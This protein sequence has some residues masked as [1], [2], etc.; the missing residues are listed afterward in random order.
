[1]G[2]VSL[3]D[4]SVTG[5]EYR[6]VEAIGAEEFDTSIL[7][8]DLTA[9]V[10]AVSVM[11]PDAEEATAIANLV[12][13]G[14][15]AIDPAGSFSWN[16]SALTSIFA[17][18]ADGEVAHIAF[19]VTIS[20]GTSDVTED[21]IIS[22]TGENDAP[23]TEDIIFS[24]GEGTSVTGILPAKDIDGDSLEYTVDEDVTNGILSL[25]MDGSFTYI[26]SADFI[27]RETFTYIATDPN[28]ATVK[29]TAFVVI[30]DAYVDLRD[31]DWPSDGDLDN[32]A[33]IEATNGNLL[34]DFSLWQ[35]DPTAFSFVDAGGGDFE[36][37]LS[38]A[39]SATHNVGVL[40]LAL[41]E[42]YIVSL[43]SGTDNA[44]LSVEFL[45]DGVVVNLKVG[46]TDDAPVF[47]TSVPIAYDPADGSFGGAVLDLSATDRSAFT[48]GSSVVSV[49]ITNNETDAVRLDNFAI[50]GAEYASVEEIGSQ[51]F[52]ASGLMGDVT[53][54]IASVE[55][56][57][58]GDKA[59]DIQAGVNLGV[60]AVDAAS[61]DFS[62][63]FKA[64]TSLFDSVPDGETIFI[65]FTVDLAGADGGT[66]S[67]TVSIAITGRNDP[68]VAEALSV[69]LDEDSSFSGTLPFSDVD[70]ETLELEI[71]DD[72]VNGTLI[73]NSDGSFTYTPDTDFNGTESFEYRV[74][75]GNGASAKNT[76]TLNVNAVNDSPVNQGIQIGTELQQ[77]D[78]MM[79]PIAV[80][81]PVDVQVQKLVTLDLGQAFVTDVDVEQNFSA[82]ALQD[83]IQKFSAEV[84]ALSAEIM[85]RET[86][87]E[88]D[89]PG[90]DE[91]ALMALKDTDP[92]LMMLRAE[93]NEAQ[94]KVDDAVAALPGAQAQ[95]ATPFTLLFTLDYDADLSGELIFL[96]TSQLFG[97]L[98]DPADDIAAGDISSAETAALA[99]FGLI[100]EGN[101]LKGSLENIN[102]F[103]KDG[104]VTLRDTSTDLTGGSGTLNVSISDG[105]NTGSGG[106]LSTDLGTIMINVIPGLTATDLTFEGTEDALVAGNVQGFDPDGDPITF[107]LVDTIPDDGIDIVT[108]QKNGADIFT[109]RLDNGVVTLTSNGFFVYTPD[110]NFAG[111]ETFTYQVSA[112][113]DID[114]AV[115][116]INL[117]DA[118]ENGPTVFTENVKVDEDKVLEN[119][120]SAFGSGALIYTL[121]P[122]GGPQNGELVLNSDGTYIY[123]PDPDFFGGDSFAFIVSDGTNS[124]T[125]TAVITVEGVQDAPD[126]QDSSVVLEEDTVLNGQLTAVDPDMEV[127]T[128]ALAEGGAPTH[129]SLMLNADGSFT[130]TPNTDFFGVDSFTYTVTD[131]I[132]TDTATFTIN[133][134]DTLEVYDDS[135][136]VDEDDQAD[137]VVA[138]Q[139]L[140]P[141]TLIFTLTTEPMLGTV[142][143]NADG[144]YSYTPDADENG[145]DSFVITVTDT[146]GTVIGSGLISVDIIPVNDA[147]VGVDDTA[148]TEEDTS[149][150]LILAGN[151]TDIDGDVLKVSEAGPAANGTVVVT[152][153]GNVLYTPDEDFYGTD[154]FT[155]T[156]DDGNGGT[157]TATATITIIARGEI[158]VVGTN[159]DDV[160]L[161]QGS[162][163]GGTGADRAFDGGDGYD[164]VRNT[165]EDKNVNLS[166]AS[167]EDIEEIDGN[168]GAI[169]VSNDQYLDLSTVNILTDVREIRGSAGNESI[170]GSRDD[171]FITGRSGDDYLEGREG[172]DT[173][174]GGLGTDTLLGNE[175]DDV[176]AVGG[177]V[178]LFGGSTTQDSGATDHFDGGIG[179]DLILNTATGADFT[180]GEASFVDIEAIDGNGGA[181]RLKTGETLDLSSIGMLINVR[182]IQAA[183]G[184]ETIIGSMD[185]DQIDGLDGYDTVIV[186]GDIE[187]YSVSIDGP[188]AA[189]I[190]GPEGT[191]TLIN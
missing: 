42:R 116:T 175:G 67:E 130:Y 98:D 18:L 119:S 82:K 137:G 95:P 169:R 56:T 117:T 49:R 132:D 106:P 179:F 162:F 185:D 25:S 52:D 133:V 115:V 114:T 91:A 61:G 101:T 54:T 97:D 86:A 109:L 147:P 73:V 156:V 180:L 3:D 43:N 100:R 148:E 28:G 186:K 99:A 35:S 94:M 30:S 153:D 65:T 189:N 177:D 78:P 47:A 167:F 17:P 64:A 87:I 29:G 50:T 38:A 51:G 158:P 58:A 85:A 125:G 32:A 145:T 190:S 8:G 142:S 166:N 21:V 88:N 59:S 111:T 121:A 39:Q 36:L 165:R 108:E 79:N 126:A 89:N 69:S 171:D 80:D 75:D 164:I 144:S 48:L 173:I 151:D 103:L 93:R 168:G 55:V 141:L 27:G 191:D 5:A 152:E 34:G 113:G 112:G 128:F 176:F 31:R 12:T 159:G 41:G 57:G 53:A 44:D 154:S 120:L 184:D 1:A 16:F 24:G 76:V 26:P 127:L 22:I 146:L 46:G 170:I 160:F 157:D 19:T 102:S 70:G 136:S 172:N 68:P 143:I 63:N 77:P 6:D 90:A 139:G 15:H 149:V 163:K 129:G 96:S 174:E 140:D 66:T 10:T 81:V 71:L 178:L 23:V 13:L 72:L 107:S 33:L 122:D 181:I 155:Y 84:T 9:T 183:D 60:Q 131:G 92:L 74:T 7:S 134:T 83:Q 118:A 11:G 182:A 62:W 45:I 40:N 188:G 104:S 187:S 161:V 110:T 4:F 37:E 123:T 135:I 150:L 14:I 138:V 20:D 2:T 105:G 124:S